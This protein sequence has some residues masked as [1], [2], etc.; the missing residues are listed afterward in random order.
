MLVRYI[1]HRFSKSVLKFK[2]AKTIKI[3][4]FKELVYS[5]YF[6]AY[7]LRKRLLQKGKSKTKVLM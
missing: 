5:Q 2:V 6:L 3:A 4:I 1:L 7:E